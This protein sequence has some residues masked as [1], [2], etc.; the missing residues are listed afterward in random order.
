LN[1]LRSVQVLR[2]VA[3]MAVVGHHFFD[4]LNSA[5]PARLG[6]AGVDLFFVISGLIM[7][8]IAS[9]R[10]TTARFL[11]DRAWRILPV[12]LLAAAP[13][14]VIYHAPRGRRADD[15]DPL[16]GVGHLLHAGADRWLESV[17]RTAFYLVFAIGLATRPWVPLAA[18]PLLVAGGALFPGSPLLSFIGNPLALGVFSRGH[19]RAAA[20]STNASAASCWRSGC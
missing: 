8:T 2:A 17:V 3:V 20:A 5:S 15:A 4:P 9:G 1:K 19:H 18:F 11:A 16:A 14:L 12:W 13:W 7:A 10:P 6:A